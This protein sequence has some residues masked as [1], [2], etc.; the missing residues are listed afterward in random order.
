MSSSHQDL[1][2]IKGNA[3]SNKDICG[4]VLQ[5]APWTMDLL[6]TFKNLKSS[7]FQFKFKLWFLPKAWIAISG[8]S[9]LQPKPLIIF[10]PS[11][12]KKKHPTSSPNHFLP[13]P[14]TSNF[15]PQT[16]PSP[17]IQRATTCLIHVL[18]DWV[19]PWLHFATF[20]HPVGFFGRKLQ[21]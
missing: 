2:T 21:S 11:V 7:T 13:L 5:F 14:T 15:Q 16:Q 17:P 20:R 3:F 12:F 9:H 19:G 8:T 1:Q 18:V 6:Q 4:M 10:I